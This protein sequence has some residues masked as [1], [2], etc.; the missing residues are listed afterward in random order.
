MVKLLGPDSLQ[1]GE[2]QLPLFNVHTFFEAIPSDP[3]RIPSDPD[4]AM[5]MVRSQVPTDGPPTPRAAEYIKNG[6]RND[7]TDIPITFVSSDVC[8]GRVGSVATGNGVRFCGLPSG[9]CTKG[10]HSANRWHSFQSGWF[11][12]GGMHKGAWFYRVPPLPSAERGGPITATIARALKDRQHPF[13]VSPGQWKLVFDEWIQPTP[14]S[15]STELSFDD[16]DY[17][18]SALPSFEAVPQLKSELSSGLASTTES[19]ESTLHRCPV[20]E[21]IIAPDAGNESGR[22]QSSS[23]SGGAIMEHS[24]E[25]RE[26]LSA[27]AVKHKKAGLTMPDLPDLYRQLETKVENLRVQL[28]QGPRPGTVLSSAKYYGLSSRVDDLEMRL[29]QSEKQ[30]VYVEGRIVDLQRELRSFDNLSIGNLQVKLRAI[31][32]EGVGLLKEGVHRLKS[33]VYAPTGEYNLLHEQ[34][35]ALRAATQVGRGVECHGLSFGHPSEVASLLRVING[36]VGIFHDAMSILHAIGSST[37]SHRSALTEMKAQRDVKIS[38][39][40]EARVITSFRMKF[41]AIL[42]YGGLSAITAV[43]EFVSLISKLKSYEVWHS[44]DG[45]SGVSQRM[46]RGNNEIKPRV[47]FLAS[48]PTHL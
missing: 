34:V 32:A 46:L 16:L 21:P 9:E 20:S 4:R 44:N 29:G 10:S 33:S 7:V 41:P 38:T 13:N 18:K 3:D 40:M 43:K 14:A 28:S 35:S 5:A 11:I 22:G 27:V 8:V 48:E 42:L 31:E 36:S 12:P 39:D 25:L 47:G 6:E 23:T 24:Q 15:P 19:L 45:V 26:P 37:T 17:A 2:S 30:R 1:T